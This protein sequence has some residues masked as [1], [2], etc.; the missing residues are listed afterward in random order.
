MLVAERRFATATEY[1]LTTALD[2]PAPVVEQMKASPFRSGMAAAAPTLRYECAVTGDQRIP[3]DHL[4]TITQPILLLAG[5]DSGVWAR[6]AAAAVPGAGHRLVPGQGHGVDQ[7]VI[8]PIL[9]EFFD[10]S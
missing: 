4:C 6:D 3:T 9:A 5:G 1:F 2:L 8:A 7:A 10:S